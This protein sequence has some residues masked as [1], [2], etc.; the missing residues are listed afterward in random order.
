MSNF[1]WLQRYKPAWQELQ[2][3]NRKI[4]IVWAM[5]ANI[6]LLADVNTKFRCIGKPKASWSIHIFWW[7]YDDNIITFWWCYDDNIIRI[8]DMIWCY[9][10]R[11]KLTHH[12]CYII[13]IVAIFLTQGLY[14]LAK[15]NSWFSQVFHQ[16]FEQHLGDC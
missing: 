11:R 6:Y 4:T 8:C 2:G 13:C 12:L 16:W 5:F 7:C 9:S 10:N 3:D 15:R 14:N 1:K